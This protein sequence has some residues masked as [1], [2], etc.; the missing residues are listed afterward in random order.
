MSPD[1]AHLLTHT[2]RPDKL[3]FA[4][5]WHRFGQSLEL[6]P[7][8]PGGAAKVLLTTD[9]LEALPIGHDAVRQGPRGHVWRPDVP[10]TLVWAEAL[11]GGDH[12][13]I[14]K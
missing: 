6:R 7:L 9:A 10:A 11:D 12:P 8:P 14:L 13:L 4:V 1:G 3:S 5:P 2:L